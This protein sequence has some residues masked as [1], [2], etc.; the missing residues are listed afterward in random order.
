MKA[1]KEFVYKNYSG[2]AVWFP[3][4]DEREGEWVGEFNYPIRRVVH[5]FVG[6]TLEQVR[7]QFQRGVDIYYSQ[8]EAVGMIRPEPEGLLGVAELME[9]ER[10]GRE[11]E[12]SILHWP[13]N[14]PPN[15]VLMIKDLVSL[16]RTTIGYNQAALDELQALFV[17]RSSISLKEFRNW[18]EHVWRRGE[19][20]RTPAGMH[21]SK[22][23]EVE[24]EHV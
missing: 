5:A 8:V 1:W 21:I 22:T 4:D 14:I 9:M 2:V 7:E 15:F 11:F 17:A 10:R 3:P 20:E 19:L 18:A 12:T 23:R 6:N 24:V 16:S 13:P